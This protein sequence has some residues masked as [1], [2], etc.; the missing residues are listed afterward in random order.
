MERI[1][2]CDLCGK[3]PILTE[4][5]KMKTRGRSRSGRREAE[6]ECFTER[7]S[8]LKRKVKNR[9]REIFA[10]S[11]AERKGG[12]KKDLPRAF[13]RG[14]GQSFVVDPEDCLEGTT[15]SWWRKNL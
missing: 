11:L 3:N 13:G 2:S 8:C 12:K 6:R 10:G 7:E 14:F 1:R 4:S 9:K 15:N 5:L